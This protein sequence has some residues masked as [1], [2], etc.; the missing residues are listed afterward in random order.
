MRGR[1]MSIAGLT[2]PTAAGIASP[3]GGF[4]SDSFTPVTTWYGGFS[5]GLLGILWF[6]ILSKRHPLVQPSAILE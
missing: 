2:W 3:L 1:Y 5:I 4:L 6:F